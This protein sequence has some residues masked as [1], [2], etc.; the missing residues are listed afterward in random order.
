MRWQ[1][2]LRRSRVLWDRRMVEDV[3]GDG[4][5]DED[6]GDNAG[7]VGHAPP[8]RWE[9]MLFVILAAVRGGEERAVVVMGRAVVMEM[10]G[11]EAGS[12]WT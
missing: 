11:K 2:K 9:L 1:P 5:A 4:L 8:M 7:P 3:A 10:V 6:S 12:R